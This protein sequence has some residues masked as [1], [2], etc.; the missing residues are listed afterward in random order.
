MLV[1]HFYE[2]LKSKGLI[3]RIKESISDD[4]IQPSR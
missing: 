2:E 1:D 3:D 4:N